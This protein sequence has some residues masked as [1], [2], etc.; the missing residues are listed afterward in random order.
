LSSVYAD[1]HP[2]QVMVYNN[3]FHADRR[4][5]VQ[6]HNDGYQASALFIPEKF[7]RETRSHLCRN[8]KRLIGMYKMVYFMQCVRVL[9]PLH[10]GKFRNADNEARFSKSNYDASNDNGPGIQKD[11]R[12]F[13]L[14]FHNIAHQ[15]L[16]GGSWANVV[17]YPWNNTATPFI[18]SL[19][20]AETFYLRG[21]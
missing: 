20:D 14:A 18:K 8:S 12:D 13:V 2:E 15:E 16:I 17:M 9:W 21:E 3:I 4:K 1:V 7:L 19:R 6:L 11:D 5:S 10:P